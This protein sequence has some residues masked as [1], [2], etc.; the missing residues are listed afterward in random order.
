MEVDFDLSRSGLGVRMTRDPRKAGSQITELSQ[1]GSPRVQ[2][3]LGHD[4]ESD[5][6]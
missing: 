4:S 6:Q 2:Q 5:C 1:N 3:F